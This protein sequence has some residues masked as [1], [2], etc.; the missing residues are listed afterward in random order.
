VV[1]VGVGDAVAAVVPPTRHRLHLVNKAGG[2]DGIIRGAA[3][4]M[5]HRPARSGRG[6]G[7]VQD[8]AGQRGQAV[9]R[10]SNEGLQRAA[11]HGYQLSGGNLKN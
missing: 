2:K 3:D 5:S 1:G 6:G 7:P 11:R 10:T 8:P 4:L 9:A